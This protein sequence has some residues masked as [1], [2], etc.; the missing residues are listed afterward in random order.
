[1]LVLLDTNHVFDDPFLTRPSLRALLAYREGADFK[2]GLP[3]VVVD[4]AV[5]Q[6]QKHLADRPARAHEELAED[7]DEPLPPGDDPVWLVRYRSRLLRIAEDKTSR[8]PLSHLMMAST[9]G[10]R[11]AASPSRTARTRTDA[12]ARIW[13]TALEAAEHERV[14]LVSANR[15]D[16]GSDPETLAPELLSDVQQ[17]GLPSDQV[18]LRPSV[19]AAL[20]ELGAPYVDRADAADLL[21]RGRGRWE[22]LNRAERAASD[23]LLDEDSVELLPMGVVGSSR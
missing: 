2:V 7:G 11:R 21:E 8:S 14:I 13:A 4:E 19:V 17:A 12:D 15:K 23:R 16:F 5:D 1:L 20:G 9:R 22:L 18:L 10:V 3:A 6:Y